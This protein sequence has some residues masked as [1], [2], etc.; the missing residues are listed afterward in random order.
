MGA[1]LFALDLDKWIVVSHDLDAVVGFVFGSSLDYY[2][3]I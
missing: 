1:Q 3:C 2:Q